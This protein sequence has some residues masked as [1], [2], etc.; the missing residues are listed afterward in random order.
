MKGDEFVLLVGDGAAGFDQVDALRATSFSINGEQVDITSKD[1]GGWRELL[2]GGGNKSVT[3]S[4]DGVWISAAHQ[5]TVRDL[6]LSGDLEDFQI[7]DSDEVLEGA[8]QVTSFEIS[9][10]QGAEQTY[11]LTLES[12]DQP[13]VT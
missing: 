10:D 6:A 12:A 5:E 3:I 2:T 11:S 1:S 8:F 13:T 7:D 9:G 4:A